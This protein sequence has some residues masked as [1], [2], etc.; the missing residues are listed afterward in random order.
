MVC[1]SFPIQISFCHMF[2][3]AIYLFTR[4]A[5]RRGRT[6]EIERQLAEQQGELKALDKLKKKK[7]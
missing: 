7:R 3:S 4:D 1:F 5:E 2:I 6:K